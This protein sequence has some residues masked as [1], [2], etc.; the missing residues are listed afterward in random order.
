MARKLNKNLVALGSAAIVTVY[1]AGFV[2]TN[3]ASID[4]AGAT[5]VASTAYGGQ[6]AAISSATAIARAIA[7]ATP[8]PATASGAT[9]AYRDGTYTGAG[10]NRFGEVDVAVTIGGGAISAVDITRS[11]TRYPVGRIAR[12]PGE[13][14]SR[15]SAG[16]DFV[17]G[18][19]YSSRAFKDAVTQALAQAAVTRTTSGAGGQA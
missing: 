1:A 12:L 18:A 2:R 17:T 16:V 3:S 9:A 10:S 11:T 7:A 19:T 6:S 4:A 8:A 13:V 15:Q 5:P 14:L